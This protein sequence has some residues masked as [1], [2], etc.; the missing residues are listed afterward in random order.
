MYYK[1]GEFD[2]ET[3]EDNDSLRKYCMKQLKY[4]DEYTD[5]GDYENIEILINKTI[6]YG[7]KFIQDQ[8]GFGVVSI[9]KGDNLIKYTS[10]QKIEY[11]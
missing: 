7:N 2:V 5:D 9:I 10:N 4:Y 11:K 1:H 8:G 6:E 3:F